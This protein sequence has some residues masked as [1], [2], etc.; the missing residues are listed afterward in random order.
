M[1]QEK[2]SNTERSKPKTSNTERPK[3]KV[4]KTGKPT[5]VYIG[6]LRYNKD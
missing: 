3:R 2:T 1:R 4:Y 6:N 5:M